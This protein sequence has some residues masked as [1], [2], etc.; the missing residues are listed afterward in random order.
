MKQ[1]ALGAEPGLAD[2]VEEDGAAVGLLEQ[3]LL[4]PG[5][6]GERA[7]HVPEQLALE[8]VLGEG[9]A[10]DGDEGL[11]RPVARQVEGPRD[12]G[13]A[14]ARLSLEEHGEIG[15][16]DLLH[17]LEQ[18]HHLGILGH[19]VGE[20]DAG[21]LAALEVVRPVGAQPIEENADLGHQGQHEVQVAG[22]EG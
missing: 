10:V 11:L 12:E 9:G 3:A 8:Q 5:R 6:P 19:H 7:L 1:P 18:A 15:A 2:L 14:R 17:Q 20:V 22:A 13:L 16:A 21:R 4:V